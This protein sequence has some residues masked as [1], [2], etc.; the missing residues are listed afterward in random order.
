VVPN[1]LVQFGISYSTDQ[2]LQSLAHK[3]IPDDPKKTDPEIHFEPG[4][5][6]YAGSGP[7]SRTSQLFI[8][9][10]SSKSLGTQLWETPIG[11]VVEGMDST[12]R[13]F[14][15]YGDMPPWGNGPVQGKIHGHPEYI[16]NDFPLT[17][18]FLECHVE[19]LGGTSPSANMVKEPERELKERKDRQ[20]HRDMRTPEML[21]TQ[22]EIMMKEKAQ[23]MNPPPT[24]TQVVA[25]A[26]VALG[27]IVIMFLMLKNRR[28][29][30]SKT[31]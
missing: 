27:V 28:K 21:E 12:V 19:R 7:N 11:K 24:S 30:S 29:I 3:S 23:M 31:S 6:S 25:V 1:F 17:D 10:G 2:D 20:R 5:I 13:N 14:Y 16:D 4:I 9:Y 15:S 22:R 18:K 8:S 26:I